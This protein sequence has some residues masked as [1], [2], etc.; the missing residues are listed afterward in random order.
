LSNKKSKLEIKFEIILNLLN[1]NNTCQYNFKGKLFD[2]Y[3]EKYNIL[4]EVDGD[5]Y[6]CNPNSKH[7][8][9]IYETQILTKKNDNFKNNLCSKFNITL[10]RYWE[11]DIN[12]RPEWVISDLKEKLSII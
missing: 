1:I 4:I 3:L 5:F 10:L 8:D 6:H 12:E 2:F 7:K 9:V 11:K